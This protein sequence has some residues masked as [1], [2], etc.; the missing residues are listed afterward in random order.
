MQPNRPA[1]TQIHKPR[2]VLVISK[3]LASDMP[4]G[5]STRAPGKGTG[6]ETCRLL[7]TASRSVLLF[8]GFG[9]DE[10]L[11]LVSGDHTLVDDKLAQDPELVLALGQLLIELAGRERCEDAGIHRVGE[12]TRV[13]AG[14]ID[15]RLG[16]LRR[17]VER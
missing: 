1:A 5:T 13:D 14:A 16:I 6:L 17:H 15:H 4:R 11:E 7:P 3:D 2:V 8:R 12:W 10:R 9:R